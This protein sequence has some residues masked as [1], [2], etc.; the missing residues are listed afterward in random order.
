MAMQVGMGLS[1]L[2]LLLGAGYT[3]SILLRNGRLSDIL[4]E[5]QDMVKGL[6][7]SAEKGAVDSEYADVL[8]SQVR[9]LAMEVRQIASA[10]PITVLNGNSG[11]GG[12]MTSLVVPTAT[13]GALGYGIMWW[14]GIS[15]SDFMYVTKRNMANA[16]ASMTKTLDQVS[17]ALAQAKKH[18]TQRIENL[19]GKLDEQK[20]ISGEIKNQVIDVHGKVENIGFE[21]NNL[22]QLL[23]GLNGRMSSIEVKQNL[24]CT[25]VMYLCQFVEGKG[26]KIPDFLVDS[27]NNGGRR[28]FLGADEHKS[29]KGLQHIVEALEIESSDASKIDAI[30]QN[31][32]NSVDNLKSKSLSRTTSLKY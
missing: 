29:L 10:R 21:L 27:P 13:L 32:A 30:M 5:L 14:K 7:K 15:F 4:S 26:G 23:C 25:G 6:E 18:L 2:V 3:G 8:A 9:R 11:I 16:V 22:Q 24:A 31:D 20:E 1:K 12:N 19:D 28:G 17:A